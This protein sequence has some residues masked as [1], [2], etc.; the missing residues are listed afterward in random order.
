MVLCD[1]FAGELP[2][3]FSSF[4]SR[5]GSPKPAKWRSARSDGRYQRFICRHMTGVT[6]RNSPDMADHAVSASE[7]ITIGVSD[8]CQKD[9]AAR[10]R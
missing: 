7:Q 4:R 3:E 10:R 6:Y 2:E 1:C 9:F 5:R 8:L